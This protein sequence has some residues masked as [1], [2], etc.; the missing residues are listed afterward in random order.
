[1]M[2]GERGCRRVAG[3]ADMDNQPLLRDEIV[4]LEVAKTAHSLGVGASGSLIM[5]DASG[6]FWALHT[7][8]LLALDYFDTET[9]PRNFSAVI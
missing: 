2:F 1:M 4:T 6:S 3:F 7:L 5:I 8:H 9:F